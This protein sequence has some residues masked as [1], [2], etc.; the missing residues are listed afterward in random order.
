MLGGAEMRWRPKTRAKNK[1]RLNMKN[2]LNPNFDKEKV[3]IIED[4]SSQEDLEEEEDMDS[5]QDQI[6]KEQSMSLQS[7]PEKDKVAEK[8]E[9][10]S[11]ERDRSLEFP[12]EEAHK[13][14]EDDDLIF[15]ENEHSLVIRQDFYSKRGTVHRF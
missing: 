13:D 2:I 3:T 4:S 1:L 5:N 15:Q 7:L 14:E 8:P 12:V 9:F 11:T 10:F 6:K